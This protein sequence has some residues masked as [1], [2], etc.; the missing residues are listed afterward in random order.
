MINQQLYFDISTFENLYDHK[1]KVAKLIEHLMVTL[2]IHDRPVEKL[3]F[4]EKIGRTGKI[5]STLTSR[6]WNKILKLMDTK[7]LQYL[8][9]LIEDKET[10]NFLSG[11]SITFDQSYEE[12]LY[13]VSYPIPNDICFGINCELVT[14]ANFTQLHDTFLETC[15]YIKPVT[16]YITMGVTRPGASPNSSVLENMLGLRYVPQSRLFPNLLRGYHWGNI[17][18]EGHIQ[19]L[20][21]LN[22]IIDDAQGKVT[23]LSPELIYFE[24]DSDINFIFDDSLRAMKEYFKPILPSDTLQSKIKYQ[25]YTQQN[26]YYGSLIFD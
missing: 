18:S 1:D 12:E 5:S 24:M 4:A 20:G 14:S 6:N 21:G 13:C 9:V 11:F 22:K 3:I 23:K 15:K 7:D 25:R 16:G 2:E 8:T 17:L 26:P 19:E 10:E